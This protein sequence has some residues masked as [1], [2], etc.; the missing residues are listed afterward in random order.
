VL[1]SMDGALAHRLVPLASNIRNE[2]AT[3]VA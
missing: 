1:S 2:H 3:A